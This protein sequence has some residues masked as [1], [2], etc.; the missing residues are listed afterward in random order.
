MCSDVSFFSV[1]VFLEVKL[2]RFGYSFSKCPGGETDVAN[3]FEVFF[4]KCSGGETDK[5]GYYSGGETD[6]L[7]YYF[8][9]E[10]EVRLG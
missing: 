6:K 3:F 2:M 5:L 10:T 7:G 9:G 8:G 1:Q 4:S